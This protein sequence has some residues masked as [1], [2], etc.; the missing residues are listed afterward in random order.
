MRQERVDPFAAEG[1]WLRCALHAHT[2]RSDGE[3]EPET[4]AAHYARAGY[5]VLAITDHWKRTE[6]ESDGLVVIA[7]AELN[8][9][10]PHARDG[11]VL[12]FG[13]DSDPGELATEYADLERTGAWIDDHGGVAYLAHPYWTGAIPGSFELP[14]NVSG[15]E[16]YNGGCELEIGRGLASVHWDEL[17]EAGQDCLAIAADDSHHPGFDSDLAWTWVRAAERSRGAVLDA[18]RRGSFYA[19][20]GARVLG[21]ELDGDAVEVR[22]SPCRSVTLLAGK[23]VGA[24]AHAG[25]LPYCHRARVLE[26][27][28]DGTITRARLELPVAARYARLELVAR[29][30]RRAWTNP[31]WT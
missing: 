31:V 19:S 21:L 26:R 5:D 7:S 11:H 30:G 16:V 24:A 9:I 23:S 28:D 2:T 4:L 3:L 29:N 22:T 14:D 25:R 15:I 13:I 6:A 17:L 12:A 1:E 10:L 27:A 8:C 18:L 20:T